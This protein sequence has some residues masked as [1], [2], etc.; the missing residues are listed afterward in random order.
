MRWTCQCFDIFVDEARCVLQVV[1]QAP[2]RSTNGKNY[3]K[4]YGLFRGKAR[5]LHDEVNSLRNF[6]S[7]GPPVGLS[8]DDSVPA[9][10]GQNDFLYTKATG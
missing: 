5:R 3:S 7:F 10:Q 6:L 2:R 9:Q 4:T 1:E 8:H